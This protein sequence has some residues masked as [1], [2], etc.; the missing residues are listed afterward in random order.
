MTIDRDRIEL[1][2]QLQGSFLEF[3]RYFYK[4]LTQRD[5]I[6][7]LPTGR[8]SHHIVLA[9]TLTRLSRLEVE[10]Q[11]L[12]INVPPGH[13][14]SLM[15]SMWVAW[16]MSIFPDC[17]FL[18]ISYSHELAAKHTAFIKQIMTSSH[19]KYLF[20]VEI[21]S[22]S[23]AKDAFK[24]TR[25]GAVSA[26]GSSG[27]ITGFDGGLPG[28]TRFSGAVIIDDPIKP[29]H[30]HSD[31]IRATVVRNYEET[32]RQ[33]P[34]GANVPIVFIGQRLHE[35]DLAAF[36]LRGDD[37]AKWDRVILKSLDENNNALYPEAFPLS[38]LLALRDKSP[39]VFASQM[40][41]DPMPAGGGLF[42]KEWFEILDEEPQIITTF[43]TADTAET[44]KTYNDA[45]V[46]SF[47]GLYEIVTMGIK[48][49]EYGLHWLDCVELFIEP[50][51][52]KQA[53]LDFWQDSMRHKIPPLIAAIEKKSTGVSLIS[54]L[55]DIRGIQ[56]RN[57]E[58]NRASGSKTQRFIEIQPHIASKHISFTKYARHADMCI[59]HMSKITA[60]D[61]HRR[62][63]IGDTCADAVKIALIDKLLMQYSQN[64]TKIA[65]TL[66]GDFEQNIQIARNAFYDNQL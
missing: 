5:F 23:R 50:K 26:H 20:D 9:R 19:Y 28:L 63:D 55:N 40:Q 47:W 2:A 64:N 54:A 38:N 29:D 32:I 60:N 15:C 8:E 43:I 33:R 42:K 10:S 13:G 51:D 18:Y 21:S 25:G 6:V 24:T 58:R 3:C 14:K 12:I 61:T 7:S 65:K 49:G 39:Y 22:D 31:T 30:A 57:I 62:D 45:T 66:F 17:N 11:R 46:F 41:Q 4:H 59:E 1:A 27:S 16:C 44:D 56:I 53:F 52:L 36:L 48:T 37:V 34:R 35:D